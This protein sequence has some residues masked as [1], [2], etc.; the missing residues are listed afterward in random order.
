MGDTQDFVDRRQARRHRLAVPIE[1]EQRTGLTRN[2]STSGLFFETDSSFPVGA[3][4]NFSL[5]LEHADPGGPFRLRCQ[6]EVMRVEPG[7]GT[8]GVAVRFTSYWFGLQG[9]SCANPEQSELPPD[10]A[11]SP[12]FPQDEGGTGQKKLRTEN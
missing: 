7:D 4:I 8:V 12:I 10:L 5:L 1:L 11:S 6:G 9:W 2:I 3:T